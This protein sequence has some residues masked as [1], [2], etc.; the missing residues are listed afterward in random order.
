MID[1]IVGGKLH[2]KVERRAGKNG[3]YF[4]GRLRVSQ[5][6]GESLLASFI[7]FDETLGARLM[8]LGPGDTVCLSGSLR[9]RIWHTNDGDARPA[10]DL[11]ATAILTAYEAKQRRGA[12]ASAPPMS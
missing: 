12:N 1:A 11:Q 8:A 10:L 4:T 5:Y 9:A 2:A 7:A 6:D 3:P